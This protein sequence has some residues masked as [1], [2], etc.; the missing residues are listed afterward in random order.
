MLITRWWTLDDIE[1]LYGKGA[2]KEVEAYRPTDADFGEESAE[3]GR[4]KFGVPEPVYGSWQGEGYGTIPQVRV[5][6]RRQW[7][8]TRQDAAIYPSGDVR[9]L[10]DG[11][12]AARWRH[13]HQGGNTPAPHHRRDRKRCVPRRL[14]SVPSPDDRALFPGVPARPDARHGGQRRVAPRNPQQRSLAVPPRS[15]Y[16]G[17][18]TAGWSR[19]TV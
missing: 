9:P 3:E 13:R 4:N 14:E 5:V 11:E 12:V 10:A 15:Q 2:R 16:H 8:L 7:K 19:R 1:L 17:K 18:A 6:E